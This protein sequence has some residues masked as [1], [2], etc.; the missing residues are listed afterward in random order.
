MCRTVDEEDI[1][2]LSQLEIGAGGQG[3]VHLDVVGDE[4]V[5]IKHGRRAALQREIDA[6]QFMHERGCK[7]C[8]RLIRWDVVGDECWI[9]MELMHTDLLEHLEKRRGA[10]CLR[11]S[12]GLIRQLCVGMH[13]VHELGMAHG[14]LKPDNVG[15]S[16]ERTLRLCDWG[17][18][19]PHETRCTRFHGTAEYAHPTKLAQTPYDNQVDD[20]WALAVC[21]FAIAFGFRPYELAHKSDPVY[22]AA[23]PVQGAST[24]V[25][26]MTMYK[27]TEMLER[28]DNDEI[29]V[30][31]AIDLLFDACRE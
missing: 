31:H 18:S 29:N 26:V 15:I 22:V 4:F 7:S 10:M 23:H 19:G 16:R 20:R 25:R 24:V 28:L 12:G 27:K 5:A 21:C 14:D 3:R 9:T 6:L 1:D 13:E 11:E 8:V 17:H 2:L 30:L